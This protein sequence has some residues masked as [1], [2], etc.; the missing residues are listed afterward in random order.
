MTIVGA[1]VGPES[2]DELARLAKVLTESGEHLISGGQADTGVVPGLEEEGGAEAPRLRDVLRR[3]GAAPLLVLGGIYSVTQ[4]DQ[5]AFATLAPNIAQTFHLKTTTLLGINAASAVLVVPLTIPWAILADRGRRA[6]LVAL[7]ATLWSVFVAFTAIA[8]TTF[9]LGLARIGI[10][11][12]VSS[13]EPVQGGM[14]ADYYPVAARSRIYAAQFTAY[15]IG[16]LLGPLVAGLVAWIA[17]G[18]SGWRWAFVVIAPLGIILAVRAMFLR[19]PDRGGHE[20]KGVV[21]APTVEAVSSDQ[22][23]EPHW[24]RI[25]FATGMHRLMEIQSLRYLY[26]GMGVLGFAVIGGPTLLSLYFQHHWGLGPLGRGVV[27]SIAAAG[28]VIG[29]PIGGIVGDRLFRTRPSWPLFL[30]G[31]SI[32]LFTIV[33]SGALYLPALW[34]VVLIYTL[35]VAV[36]S[37]A[38]APLRMMLAAI[39]PPPLRSLSFAMLNIATFL[40]GGLLGGILLGAISDATNPRFAYTLLII[41]GVV[42]GVLVVYGSRFVTADIGMVVEDIKEA[43][44]SAQRRLQ[45]SHN[46]VEVRNVDFFYGPVQILFGIDLDV[47]EGE[48]FSLLGTNGAGKSTLLRNICGLEHPLRGSIRFL[49]E[50]TT[51]LDAEQLITLGISLMPGGKGVFPLLSVEENLRMGGYHFARDKRRIDADMEQIYHWFP[52]LNERRR[53]PAGKLSG[54]E[55]QMLALS[56]AFILRPR[57][58][59]IDELALGLSPAVVQSLLAIL[60]EMNAKGTS[61]IIVDQSVGI[62]LEVST[63]TA[64][65]EKGRVRFAGPTAELAG[66]PDLIRSVFLAGAIPEQ[67]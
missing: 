65:L 58:L 15:P 54:G 37:I 1:G 32:P 59:C 5:N 17:G 20:R 44:R 24:P 12:G 39:A 33:A 13:L 42:A 22:V 6:R 18:K 29:L 11:S 62:A 31:A 3:Y 27:F 8:T 30:M 23:S 38:F 48:I 34:A 45:G 56:R 19:E 21:Q 9:L 25:P 57:L 60:R 55:Q 66:R 40:M 51:Y 7:G 14:L 64:F 36:T 26:V 49:G 4:L 43:D 63:K 35:A 16:G 46:L 67:P 53:Q 61:M 50:D 2:P 41:P 47:P 52:V 28:S 10:G